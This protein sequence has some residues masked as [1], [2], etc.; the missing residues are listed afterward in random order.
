VENWISN[1]FT[2]YF[3]PLMGY[4]FEKHF[5]ELQE[6]AICVRNALT[7]YVFRQSMMFYWEI[8]MDQLSLNSINTWHNPP[9][10]VGWTIAMLWRKKHLTSSLFALRVHWQ[11]MVV[12]QLSR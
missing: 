7:L 12:E 6:E 10:Q 8:T 2:L 3:L 4:L 1:S 11:G 5:L 9:T